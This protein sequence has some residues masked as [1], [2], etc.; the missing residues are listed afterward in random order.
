MAELTQSWWTLDLWDSVMG[1]SDGWEYWT[2]SID[3]KPEANGM[4]CLLESSIDEVIAQC[5][6]TGPLEKFDLVRA[7]KAEGYSGY[8]IA[9]LM[10][11]VSNEWVLSNCINPSRFYSHAPATRPQDYIQTAEVRARSY[12]KQVYGMKLGKKDRSM[13]KRFIDNP[14]GWVQ[15]SGLDRDPSQGVSSGMLK[16]RPMDRDQWNSFRKLYHHGVFYE[17][18]FHAKHRSAIDKGRDCYAKQEVMWAALTPL[19]KKLVSRFGRDILAGQ[20]VR[21]TQDAKHEWLL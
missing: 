12:V 15:M 7:C 1:S 11:G 14:D 18:T 8:L 20:R 21:W 9:P 5:P 19:G 16:Y 6:A 3:E 13:L 2:C 10:P 17:L 4:A